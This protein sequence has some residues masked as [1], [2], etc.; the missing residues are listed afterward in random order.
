MLKYDFSRDTGQLGIDLWV[1]GDADGPQIDNIGIGDPQPPIPCEL[2]GEPATHLARMVV[3]DVA[4]GSPVVSV[5]RI[6]F[7]CWADARDDGTL[8][9]ATQIE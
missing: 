1:V 5:F 2:C 3:L 8:I 9:R 7:D 4:T 6:G